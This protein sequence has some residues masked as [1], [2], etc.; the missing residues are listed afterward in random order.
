MPSRFA[1]TGTGTLRQ[2]AAGA[3][4]IGVSLAAQRDVWER[5][6]EEFFQ[7]T[8]IYVHVITGRLRRSGRYDTDVQ[9][10]RVVGT[11]EYTAPYAQYEIDAGGEHDFMGRAWE[12]K[13]SGF[14]R[15]QGEMFLRAVTSWRLL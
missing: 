11:V 4:T 2:W 10:P 7:L 9:G 15:A 5:E 14:A 12:E 3:R 6:T 8:Q 1:I 13:Q